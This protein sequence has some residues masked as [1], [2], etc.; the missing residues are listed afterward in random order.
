MR[1]MGEMASGIA[2]DF[3]N[4]LSP[5][6][7]FSG[8]LLDSPETLND[9]ERALED[10][11]L[12][13]TAAQDAANIVKRLRQFYREP[14]LD[15][16][17][18]E[19]NVNLLVVQSVA[20]TEPKWRG[21]SQAKG[22]TI[23][24]ETDLQQVPTVAGSESEFREALTN[25]IINAV[26]A[27]SHDGT[28]GVG[29]R[30][31][32]GHVAI[33][34]SDTGEGMSEEVRMRCMDP[35]FS[36]KGEQG[37][38]MGLA[39]VYGIVGRLRGTIDIASKEGEGTTFTIRLPSGTG[40][41]GLEKQEEQRQDLKVARALAVLVVDDDE[42][43]RAVL[44]RILEADGHSVESA[45]D[46]QEGLRK[47]EDGKFDLVVTDRAMPNMNGDQM[48]AAIRQASPEVPVIMVT[49]FGDLMAG[50][51]ERPENIDAVVA[52]PIDPTEFRETVKSL[53]SKA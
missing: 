29:T 31:A 24:I 15:Q 52:K 53:M 34:V 11:R 5:I 20:L 17:T 8:M 45:S 18:E 22:V 36:T 3:N 16:R 35:F 19:L 28:I 30:S 42:R 21:Q 48:A 25:L 26:D 38:G 1:A 49:G 14:D 43:G 32:N 10:I 27:L 13:H 9:T 33:E 4:A 39:M 12:M 44:T 46:G 23:D 7:S 51:G 6:V 47:L 2:H 41:A 50:N 37:T 40:S